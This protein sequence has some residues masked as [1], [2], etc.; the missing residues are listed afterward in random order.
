MKRIALLLTLCLMI[1]NLTAC[2]TNQEPTTSVT[3]FPQANFNNNYW[4]SGD[5]WAFDDTLFYLQDGF[6]NMGAYWNTNGNKEKLFEESDF[7]AE[8]SV[9]RKIFV[10]DS[11]LYF[12]L[13][14]N[15]VDK[16]Y[17]YDLKERTYAPVCEPPVCIDGWL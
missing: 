3:S 14:S 1:I 12:C 16:L 15:Q 9:I 10:C 8:S 13:A 6:Y 11:Y 7:S 17:R 2:S 5:F 4:F